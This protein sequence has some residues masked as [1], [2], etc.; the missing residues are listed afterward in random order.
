MSTRTPTSPT[1]P[2]LLLA[3]DPRALEERLLQELAAAPPSDPFAPT[4]IVAPT[5]RL[6][7]HL[8]FTL[9]T[10]RG[11]LAG[12]RFLHHQSLA[13]HVLDEAGAP[14][15]APA[16]DALLEALLVGRLA[17]SRLALAAYLA[18]QPAAIAAL[19]ATLRDLRDAGVDAEAAR[20]ADLSERGKEVVALLAEHEEIVAAL[21]RDGAT[22]G[23][24]VARAATRALRA[25]PDRAARPAR[26]VHYG[27]YEL[28]GVH[29]ELVTS[30]ARGVA[31]SVY[32]PAAGASERPGELAAAF[33]ARVEAIATAPRPARAQSLV[34]TA[35]PREEMRLAAR[36]LLRWHEDGVPFE[37]TALLAR[38]G[39]GH[40]RALQAEAALLECAPD[41]S[42]ARPLAELPDAL[43][44]RQIVELATDP[45]SPLRVDRVKRAAEAAG[46]SRDAEL[47]LARDFARGPAAARVAALSSWARDRGDAALIAELA[48]AEREIARHPALA[49]LLDGRGGGGGAALARYVLQRLDARRL[50]PEKTGRLRVLELHQARALPFRRAVLIGAND[51]LLPRRA[52]E[53]YFLSDDDRRAL[54]EAT[55]APLSL[56]GEARRD[57]ELLFDTVCAAVEEELVV[58]FAR[59]DA[60]DRDA[61][62]SPFLRRLGLAATK[63]TPLVPRSPRSEV[64]ALRERTGLLAP[65]EALAAEVARADADGAPAAVRA[66]GFDGELA[67]AGLARIAA[68][69]SFRPDDLRFDGGGVAVAER[70]G[71][72]PSGLEQLGICPLQFFFQRELG[73]K[74]PPEGYAGEIDGAALGNL[75]HG[76]L[77]RLYRELLPEGAPIRAA[78]ALPRARE[79]VLA[80]LEAEA[81]ATPDF[82][83]LAPRFRRLRMEQLARD[84]FVFV[85]A[86][87]ARCEALGLRAVAFE[88]VDDVEV[89]AG[90]R[91][92]ALSL[93]LDR[94]LADAGGDEWIGDYKTSAATKL[95]ET[96]SVRWMARGKSLQLPLY[97][98]A[99]IA[100]GRRVG[101]LE[102]LALRP[103]RRPDDERSVEVDVD[104]LAGADAEV[105]DTLDAL[106]E[107]RD[108]GHFPLWSPPNSPFV[109]CS[110]C[111]FRR[112]CRHAHAPT[113]VRVEAAPE[114]ARF[115]AL[116]QKSVT[117]SK[118]GGGPA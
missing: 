35:G 39:A 58:T 80:C 101:G 77:C 68:I 34:S 15:L 10:K 27:A 106:L 2:R 57:D 21:E 30:L 48:E 59:A 115:F 60:D 36:T 56:R 86:D 42:F 7:D 14:P 74:R 16:S 4:W 5:R 26:L 8:A 47:A 94:L 17:T 111:E 46:R 91:H 49:A 43:A 31:A 110:R 71:W 90:K 93:R 88:S 50:A 99:R 29:R 79:R 44:L 92:L 69:D 33:G 11:A 32:V 105:A 12:V 84:L 95:Q 19:R 24:G 104:A 1:P 22:D 66:L 103:P 67:A 28:I 63:A 23:A 64:A 109:R 89:A 116:A 6:L 62:P 85:E 70:P 83:S 75:L 87:L 9:A 102:L 45:G 98:L 117:K 81:A 108:S 114:H 51:R 97:R 25:A 20:R 38:G 53:D 37:E 55:G 18:A 61:S 73:V 72:S 3:S 40:A 82:P 112:A 100:R 52:S 107:L 113:R 41:T 13:A 65:A 96:A 76:A 118:G 78:D 54:R